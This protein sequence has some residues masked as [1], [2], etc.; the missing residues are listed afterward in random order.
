MFI[1]EHSKYHILQ[2]RKHLYN[3]ETVY[4]PPIHLLMYHII[5][6]NTNNDAPAVATTTT[7]YVSQK[8]NLR[9][10][11]NNIHSVSQTRV[12]SQIRAGTRLLKCVCGFTRRHC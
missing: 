1:I 7:V 6:N 10:L 11:I 3:I 9:G 12:S 5:S 8:R 2:P 4:V